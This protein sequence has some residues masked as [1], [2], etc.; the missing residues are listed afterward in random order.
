MVVEFP[1]I[2]KTPLIYAGRDDGGVPDRYGGYS[3]TGLGKGL[4]DTDGECG[5]IRLG[6]D[7]KD[8]ASQINQCA[9][10]AFGKKIFFHFVGN[11]SNSSA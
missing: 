10:Y 5:T 3:S 7:G 6:T 11:E 4:L 9:L 1:V 8:I 2:F